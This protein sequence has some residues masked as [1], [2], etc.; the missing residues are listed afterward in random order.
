MEYSKLD[1][2]G[3]DVSPICL[4]CVSIGDAE[5]NFA[6]LRLCVKN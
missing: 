6:S 1:K 3:L 2:I 4:G 5:S